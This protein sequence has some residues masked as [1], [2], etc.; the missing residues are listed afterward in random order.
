MLSACNREQEAVGEAELQADIAAE[1]GSPIDPNTPR[2]VPAPEQTNEP[3]SVVVAPGSA[4]PAAAVKRDTYP[5]G[6]IAAK[7]QPIDDAILAE[8]IAAMDEARKRPEN[9]A[10]LS[11]DP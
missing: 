7:G 9:S 10:G 6:A 8:E 4:L 11:P 2:Y 5:E 1:A 3:V